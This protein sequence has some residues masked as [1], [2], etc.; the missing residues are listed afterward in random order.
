M[1]WIP[2]P[3]WF[4]LTWVLVGGCRMGQRQASP[5][6]QGADSAVLRQ[7]K[8]LEEDVAALKNENAM[9]SLQVQELNAREKG[10]SK[11]LSD[12]QFANTQQTRQIEVLAAAPAER[13]RYKTLAEQLAI[14]VRRL[15][16]ELEWLRGVTRTSATMP[17]TAPAAAPTQPASSHPTSQAGD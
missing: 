8:D 9:L 10:L 15:E 1:R 17:S 4:V 5:T 16:R 11:A 2:V 3:A 6:T 14:E 7:V 12:L 13:D